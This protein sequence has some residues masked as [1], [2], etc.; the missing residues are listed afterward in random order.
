VWAL[1]N[2]F[3]RTGDRFL[4]RFQ[5]TFEF[6]RTFWLPELFHYILTCTILYLLLVFPNLFHFF[7]LGLQLLDLLPCCLWANYI[8]SLLGELLVSSFA[9]ATGTAAAAATATANKKTFLIITSFRFDVA[10]AFASFRPSWP[11]CATFTSCRQSNQ[12]ACLIWS[13]LARFGNRNRSSEAWLT[14]MHL[15]RFLS[16]IIG[17]YIPTMPYLTFLLSGNR[18]QCI[19]TSVC[20][21]H[22]P[23]SRIYIFFIPMKRK[24]T[25]Y[26]SLLRNKYAE[27]C[28]CCICICIH[29]CE[30]NSRAG[31]LRRK[32]NKEA[33]CFFS[34]W[35]QFPWHDFHI[36]LF[37]KFFF[38]YPT[39]FS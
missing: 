2:F 38:L 17:W 24:N 1:R 13:D 37:F 10:V 15:N 7:Y 16:G 26:L 6:P 19:R 31:N 21:L 25:F 8:S 27:F 9:A 11:H 34:C 29:L 30:F 3:G 23:L 33:K 14:W 36:F 20:R 39:P 35:L 4:R 18:C 28:L 32:A 22:S 5:L 12:Q